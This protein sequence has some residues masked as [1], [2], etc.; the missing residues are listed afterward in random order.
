VRIL[1]AMEEPIGQ[2][3][4]KTEVKHYFS[5]TLLIFYSFFAVTNEL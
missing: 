1:A 3:L 4:K 2:T 5:F